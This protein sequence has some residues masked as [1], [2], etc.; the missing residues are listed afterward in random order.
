MRKRRGDARERDWFPAA[1]ALGIPDLIPEQCAQQIP[2]DLISWRSGRH[3]PDS[4]EGQTLCFFVDD[5]RFECCWTYPVRMLSAL[6]RSRWGAVCEPNF[7]IW[8]DGPVAEQIWNTYRTRWVGRYWQ[9]H[10]IS[11]IPCLAIGTPEAW[12]IVTSGVP[13]G[14]P[15]VSIQTQ[16]CTDARILSDGLQR[17]HEAI[18]FT[19]VLIYGARKIQIP[20]GV[21]AHYY[22][23]RLGRMRARLLDRQ[24]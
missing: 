18:G 19:D 7:S 23:T 4:S 22:Q 2:D 9:E 17:A 10:G 12:P 5:W 6:Q 14:V 11:V 8:A 13:S 20:D 3:D 16:T 24:V 21:R 1:N 15:V